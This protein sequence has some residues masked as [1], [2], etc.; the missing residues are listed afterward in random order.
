MITV[1]FILCIKLTFDVHDKSKSSN[2][3]EH[4]Y[5]IKKKQNRTVVLTIQ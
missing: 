3:S 1:I 4:K 2:N 5:F